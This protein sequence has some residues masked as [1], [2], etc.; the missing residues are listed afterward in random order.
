MVSSAVLNTGNVLAPTIFCRTRTLPSFSSTPKKNAGVAFEPSA[1]AS[2]ISWRT[3]FFAASPAMHCWKAAV[4]RPRASALYEG[5]LDQR[6]LVGE[7]PIVPS[8]ELALRAGTL[9]GHSRAECL[10][11]KVFE[12][13]VPEDVPHL[14]RVHVLALDLC[15]GVA[16]V[17]TAE[18]ALEI[19][20]LD[21]R[22][23]GFGVAAAGGVGYRKGRPRHQRR[24][25]R[26][27]R[28]R[29]LC[30]QQGLDLLQFL[31]DGL[32]AGL[33]RGNPFLNACV[34]AA[35]C[36]ASPVMGSAAAAATTKTI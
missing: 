27:R 25:G 17:A 31:Q 19:R 9:S 4:S 20:E 5:R 23:L 30:L 36:C 1:S 14:S 3:F 22:Q 28:G 10:W 26:R 33:E 6:A 13:Q 18:R 16:R 11:V 35:V 12:W 34:S 2:A 32:L 8:P 15:V 24:R 7:H 21:E 29:G